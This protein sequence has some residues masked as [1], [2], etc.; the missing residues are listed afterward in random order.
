MSSSIFSKIPQLRR[1]VGGFRGKLPAKFTVG[2][3]QGGLGVASQYTT[4]TSENPSTV[5]EN[6]STVSENP[7]TVSENP[8]TVLENPSTV[9][10]NPSTVSETPSRESVTIKQ[11]RISFQLD[12]KLSP[13]R[14]RLQSLGD[15]LS[16]LTKAGYPYDQICRIALRGNLAEITVRSECA[17]R[18]IREDLEQSCSAL[19]ISPLTE[20]IPKDYHI[21]IY[22]VALTVNVGSEEQYRRWSKDNHTVII[23]TRRVGNRVI[24]KFN[25]IDDA[26]RFC[27]DGFITLDGQRYEV[28]PYDMRQ[29][30]LYCFRCA[31]PSHM[32]STCKRAKKCGYCSKDHAHRE[33][34]RLGPIKCPHCSGAHVAWSRDCPNPEVQTMIRRCESIGPPGWAIANGLGDAMK[35]KKPKKSCKPKAT[36]SKAIANAR[37]RTSSPADDV[38]S[39]IECDN[40]MTSTASTPPT[41][42]VKLHPIFNMKK[43][44][45]THVAV[46]DS[47]EPNHQIR[48][49]KRLRSHENIEAVEQAEVALGGK[50]QR[51]SEL[52]TVPT[53][54]K[55][56]PKS[57]PQ[58]V[59]EPESVQTPMRAPKRRIGRRPGSKTTKR[60]S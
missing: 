14:I 5:S 31:Q 45:S 3:G 12:V 9:S 30:P 23:S 44:K 60:S 53:P 56:S 38:R 4:T 39:V 20:E 46:P 43:R 2:L 40:S 50:N 19:G 16:R 58:S 8:S 52:P 59:M 1:L 29:A 6:P 34:D 10:E 26:V 18:E 42:N 22:G 15:D 11:D 17:L 32:A 13:D 33:C 21:A 49:S 54:D 25:S 37:T 28:K 47:S 36:I 55:S 51:G 41:S 48:R 35:F 27:R 24:C 57:T 7:S